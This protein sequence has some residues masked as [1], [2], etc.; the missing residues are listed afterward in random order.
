[1]TVGADDVLA[2][3]DVL[4]DLVG[5]AVGASPHRLVEIEGLLT[6]VEQRTKDALA[7]VRS[8]LLGAC[9]EPVRVGDSIL[10][11]EPAGK[12]RPDHNA[13]RKAIVGRALFDANG[14]RITDPTDAATAAVAVAYRC[15]VSPSTMP[16]AG[17]LDEL[18]VRKRDIVE[19]EHTGTELKRIPVK[20]VED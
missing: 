8:E 17:A 16:K 15:F 1:M 5:E 18:H 12:W 6:E 13:I 4:A 14:E 7:L 3:A 9:H 20:A 10:R 19:W 2:F 11:A